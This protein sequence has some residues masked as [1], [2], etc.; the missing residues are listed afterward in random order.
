[1]FKL[2]FIGELPVKAVPLFRYF[3]D[4][5]CRALLPT[6]LY[7][8]NGASSQTAL[9]LRSAVCENRAGGGLF[10]VHTAEHRHAFD[11]DKGKAFIV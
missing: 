3:D 9:L 8:G 6:P 7:K 2:H 10:Y 5:F 4:W 11:G 1:M